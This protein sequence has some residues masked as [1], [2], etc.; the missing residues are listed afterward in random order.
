[1]QLF[2]A[3]SSAQ[4]KLLQGLLRLKSGTPDAPNICRDGSLQ[5]YVGS[6]DGVRQRLYAC[7]SSGAAAGV[8]AGREIRVLKSSGGSGDG[9][10]PLV[11]GSERRF[12]D[13]ASVSRERCA[14]ASRRLPEAD[15]AAFIE[16]RGCDFA[17]LRRVPDAG[18][19]DLEP[20]Q[21]S[22]DVSALVSRPLAQL[23]WALPVS[24]NLRNALQA[25]QG[26]VPAEVAHDDAR[27][28]TLAAMPGL[29]GVQLSSILVGTLQR[30]SQL[31]D[32]LGVPI[33][34]SAAL[35][36][37]PPAKERRSGSRPGAFRPDAAVGDSVYLCRRVARSGTQAAFDLHYLGAGCVVGAP[38]ML[39]PSDGSSAVSGGDP[40]QLLDR[41]RPAGRVFAGR[42]S[43]DV[44]ACL[45]IHDARNRWAVGMLSSENIGNNLAREFRH[46]RVDG[47]APTLLNAH[48]GTWRHVS[49]TSMQWRRDRDREFARSEAGRVLRFIAGHIG[50]PGVLRSLNRNFRHSWGVGGYLGRSGRMPAGLIPVSAEGLQRYP[51]LGTAAVRGGR[52]DACQRPLIAGDSAV[53]GRD[54]RDSSLQR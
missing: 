40:R 27:R 22:D 2:I 47:V 44:R 9:V 26:L 32:Q 33:T 1:M 13:P 25:L 39:A 53:G 41:E 24:R 28:E 12:F 46:I 7:V 36:M 29:T 23:V 11:Q 3:G 31:Y 14:Q 45:D 48:R 15:L 6:V 35:A 17:V 50:Q 34:R 21:F 30:W 5:A 10:V 20:A 49:R 8:P 52:P 4:D 16:Y 19:S 43:A 54:G 42:G 18:I 51:L 37:E 38:P